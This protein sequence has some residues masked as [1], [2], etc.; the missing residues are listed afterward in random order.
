MKYG[1]ILILAIVL[2]AAILFSGSGMQKSPT[3]EPTPQPTPTSIINPGPII[4]EAIRSHA[5]LETIVMS[6]VNDMD[7]TRVSGIAGVCTEKITYLAYY[8]VTAGVDLAKIAAEDVVVNRN[9][10]QRIAVSIT[11]PKAEIVNV[12]LNTQQSRLVA[13]TSPKWVPGC[14]TQVAAMTLEAQQKIGQQVEKTA[15]DKGILKMAQEKA[16]FELQRLI[17]SLGYL[18]VAIQYH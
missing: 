5:K 10:P 2:A 4:I 12:V 14:E 8:D 13:Q 11:L 1:L 3:L 17:F 15:L 18:N 9:D 7:V 6:M 16:G